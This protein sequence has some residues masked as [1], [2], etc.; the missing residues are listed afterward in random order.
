MLNNL[1]EEKRLKSKEEELMATKKEFEE[2]K[3]LFNGSQI[4]NRN[5][6]REI[7]IKEKEI[8][9]LE[10]LLDKSREETIRYKLKVKESKLEILIQKLEVDR[11][12]IR[13]LRKTY[14][15][16]IV[17][18][19]NNNQDE[20]EDYDD[21]IEKIKDKLI[22]GGINIVDVQ[23]LCQKCERIAKLKVEQ[24]KLYKERFEAKCPTWEEKM[25]SLE[26][27]LESLDNNLQEDESELVFLE[28]RLEQCRVVPDNA[29]LEEVNEKKVQRQQSIRRLKIQKKMKEQRVIE[30]R[31]QIQVP[32]KKWLEF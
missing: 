20:I 25:G 29:L 1:L 12:Q 27:Q 6:D 26:E 15:K 11:V 17:V 32:P 28:W 23:K 30:L 18:C 2:L 14:Q 21:E 19:A 8:K 16:F 7:K 31:T 9:E 5:K 22:D 4:E 13:D 24:D 3:N 10:E